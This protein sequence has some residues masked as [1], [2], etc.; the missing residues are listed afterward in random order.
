M[1]LLAEKFTFTGTSKQ[2]KE[3]WRQ[4]NRCRLYLQVLFLSDIASGDGKSM[5]KDFFNYQ[6]RAARPLSSQWEWPLQQPAKEDWVLWH[7]AMRQITTSSTGGFER[8]LHLWAWL[9]DP[10]QQRVWRYDPVGG[11]LF[12]YKEELNV[13]KCYRAE[14]SRYTRRTYFSA[15]GLTAGNHLPPGVHMPVVFPAA[16]TQRV[17]MAGYAPLH[18]MQPYHPKTVEM[19]IVDLGRG[20]W[21]LKNSYWGW[22]S[23]LAAAITLGTAFAVAD[24]SHMPK[25][26]REHGH[27]HGLCRRRWTP[28]YNAGG[29]AKQ[30]A[31]HKK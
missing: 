4:L 16:G 5:A 21:P 31:Q 25:Q 27:P 23:E 1:D 13:W 6:G 24:G 10:H 29:N 19:A 11:F 7:A 30:V 2:R 28:T 15:E 9:R 18:I 12:E 14:S 8:K 3:Q 20:G 17:E 22:A 26:S